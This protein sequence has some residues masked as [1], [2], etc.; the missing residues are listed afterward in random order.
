MFGKHSNKRLLI[1]LVVVVIV[2]FSCHSKTPKKAKSPLHHFN[3]SRIYYDQG[4]I[5][6]AIAEIEKA[7]KLDNKNARFYQFLGFI[8]FS[9][10]DYPKAEEAYLKSLEIKPDLTDVRN[11]LGVLYVHTDRLDQAMKEFRKLI[12]EEGVILD[13]LEEKGSYRKVFL[14]K[15]ERLEAV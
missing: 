10:G 7:I 12:I 8:H 11:H 2:F 3:R 4:R 13:E 1:L 5:Q 6:E 9:V 14:T 15:E